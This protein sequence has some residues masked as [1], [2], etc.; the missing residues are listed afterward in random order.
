MF[1]GSHT[2]KI[3]K[4]R[5][6]KAELQAWLQY[7]TTVRK[8]NEEA[9]A[10]KRAS[11]LLHLVAIKRVLDI[12]LTEAEALVTFADRTL[13]WVQQALKYLAPEFRETF[14]TMEV[15][16]P[17]LESLYPWLLQRHYLVGLL[18]DGMIRVAS[19]QSHSDEFGFD[20]EQVDMPT[21]NTWNWKLKAKKVPSH[22]QLNE[23]PTWKEP[24]LWRRFLQWAKP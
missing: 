21:T 9:S 22:E 3:G 4:G 2:V 17:A 14:E 11:E 12:P 19:V 18:D 7:K 16:N 20:P 24:S 23:S 13:P 8:E 10:G 15:T 1:N 6:R 5:K